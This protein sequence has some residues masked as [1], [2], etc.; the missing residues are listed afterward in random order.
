MRL[1]SLT[2]TD[3]DRRLP[4]LA[5]ILHACVRDGASVGFVLP[6]EIDQAAAFF[7]D[8]VR[9]GLA[10]GGR[11]LLAAELDDKRGGKL[12]GTVQLIHDTPPNQPHRAEVAKLLVHP[13]AR[14][15]GLARALMTR[16]EAEARARGRSLLTLDTRTGDSAEPLYR[17][18]GY[19]T[20]GIIPGYCRD[21]LTERLDATTIMYKNL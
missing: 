9:P 18:L 16:L 12:A 5:A 21:T 3:L 11:V 4:E 7:R 20:T 17:S 10:A 1:L 19:Q 14:R 2:P 8:K 15:R 13:D 6:F